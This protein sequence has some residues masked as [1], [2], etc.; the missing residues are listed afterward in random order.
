MSVTS[1]G[2]QSSF[3]GFTL[4]EFMVALSIAAVMM[5]YAIPAFRDFTSQR[6]MAAN[7]N[8]M[9]AAVNYARSEA[10]RLGG[11]V[12]VQA[13][14]GADGNN[15][16]GPGFCVTVG[17]PGNCNNP[18]KLFAV[19]GNGTFDG[20]GLL[21]NEETMSFNSRGM[22]RDGLLGAIELCG[23]DADD[24]PGRIIN[25]NAVGRASVTDFVCFP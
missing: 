9:I 2:N 5:F 19:D 11:I 6:E 3:K 25:I 13:V 8:G 18:L 14:N 15:E 17:D 4:V 20:I 7:V 12:S 16:W 21:D 23:A 22:I 10:V 24:D 1:I